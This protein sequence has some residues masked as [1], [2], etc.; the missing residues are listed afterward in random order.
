MINLPLVKKVVKLNPYSISP[1][2]L[3]KFDFPLLNNNKKKK[4]IQCNSSRNKVNQI[5]IPNY[6]HNWMEFNNLED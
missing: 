3:Q 5:I 1:K 4:E 6:N 2:N